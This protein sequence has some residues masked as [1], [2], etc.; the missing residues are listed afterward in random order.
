M[1]STASCSNPPDT[2]QTNNPKPPKNQKITMLFAGDVMS[3]KPQ[4]FSTYDAKTKKFDYDS[5]FKYVKDI[6]ST[7]DLSIANLET[8]LA[9]APYTGYPTF[10]APD[11]LAYLLKKAGFDLLTTANNHTCDKGKNGIIRTIEQLDRQNLLHTGSWKNQEEKEKS[12]PMVINKNGFKIVMLNYTYGTNGIPVPKPT[13]VNLIDTVQIKKDLKKANS[14]NPDILLVMMHAGDEYVQKLNWYQTSVTDICKRNGVDLLIGA[15]P[16]V[17]QRIDTFNIEYKGKEKKMI[18]VYSMGNYISAQRT[19]FTEGGIMVQ[20]E[21][22]KNSVTKDT[23]LSNAKYIPTWVHI[24]KQSDGK[25]IW[26]VLPADSVEKGNI[27]LD[28]TNQKN[29]NEVIAHTRKVLG[30]E[31]GPLGEKYWKTE[32]KISETVSAPKM[33]NYVFKVQI[34]SYSQP[35]T[36][37]FELL[38]EYLI[39]KEEKT[40]NLYRYFAGKF[41]DYNNAVTLKKQLIDKGYKDAFV[42]AFKDGKRADLN[43]AIKFANKK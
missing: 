6:V 41:S 32:T 26:A 42:V 10:C 22:T 14:M 2:S 13:V 25:K 16:H 15:H 40:N 7:P 1:I 19:R 34:G 3:H 36:K 24:K 11:T 28:V 33:P 27:K 29:F 12:Y 23:W 4:I 43:T 30:D 37:D 5:W 17:V 20:V 9:G 31:K 8:T 18:A 35:K 21:F 38:K 39:I